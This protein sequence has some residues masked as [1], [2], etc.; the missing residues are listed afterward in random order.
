MEYICTKCGLI[1]ETEVSRYPECLGEVRK[2]PKNMK[3]LGES[4]R[5]SQQLL[6]LVGDDVNINLK[7]ATST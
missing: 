4:I 1:S 5:N 3:R 2:F 7:K 6:R